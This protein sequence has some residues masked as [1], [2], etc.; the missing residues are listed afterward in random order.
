MSDTIKKIQRELGI[1]ET[2][3]VDELTQAAW[4]NYCIKNGTEFI[5]LDGYAVVMENHDQTSGFLSTDY[6]EKA[7]EVKI[8]K[9]LLKQG[10]FQT[11]SAKKEYIFLHFTAGWENPFRV[12]DDWNTDTRGTI[13][14]QYVIG[15]RNPQTLA[16]KYD[17][18]IIQT[19]TDKDYAWHLG[20]G[21]TP[22]HRNS[23]GI[24]V[25]NFGAL[26]KVGKDFMS[27]A[28]RR[29]APSEV[30]DLKQEFRGK[31]YFHKLTNEQLESLYFILHYISQSNGIDLTKGLKERLSK[32]NKFKAF[33]YD[34]E[35]RSGKLRGVFTHTN[36]S[37]KNKYGNF[38]KWDLFPQD[39][40]ID[41][42]NSL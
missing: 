37:P 4:K 36:V 31:R 38:E 41:L 2:G 13:G 12:V 28:N 8:T 40:L 1:P 39:E 15:G 35:I 24:E 27:W 16:D 32:M 26:D 34:D 5:P 22:M 18:Q 42:I 20:I 7:K 29:I 14:T 11:G 19:M 6:Q 30:V 21:N 25:C 33:D 23:V 3:I 17:G 9:Y 10:Q